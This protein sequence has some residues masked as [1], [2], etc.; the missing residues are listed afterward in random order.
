MLKRLSY[1]VVLWLS[2]CTVLPNV[3]QLPLQQVSSK[4]FKIE[5]NGRHSLLLIQFYEHKWR[6]VQ[7]DPLGAP[8]ARVWLTKKGW[9]QDGFI[10]PNKQAQL[11]FTALS[12]ALNPH[13]PPFHLDKDWKIERENAQFRIE[14]PDSSRWN[15]EM[16]EE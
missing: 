10:M 9:E 7:T 1:C 2:A 16:L 13:S 3:E 11:L 6:W 15:V 14:L 8:I 4:S 5:N 12:N